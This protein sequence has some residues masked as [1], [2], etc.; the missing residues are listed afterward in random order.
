MRDTETMVTPVSGSLA[1]GRLRNT[2]GLEKKVQVLTREL[3]EALEL[4]GRI[5]EPRAELERKIAEALEQQTA[6]AKVLRVIS[7]SPGELAPVF[8]AILENA[9]RLC[10]AKFGA[11]YL[12]EGSDAFQFVAMHNA[13]PAF[14]E[15][16]RRN[17]VFRPDPRIALARAAAMKQRVQIVD[18]QAEPGYLDSSAGFSGSQIAMLAGG[19]TKAWYHFA[20]AWHDPNRRVTW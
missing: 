15:I 8:Q 20:I 6:I 9:R 3:G 18:V 13:P 17:P 16:W 10:E 7:T 12:T 11:M 4:A 19:R 5:C 1:S 14:A 2:Q